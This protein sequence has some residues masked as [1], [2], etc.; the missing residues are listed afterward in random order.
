MG[1]FVTVSTDDSGVATVRLDRPKV[2]AL[3]PQ[4]W[5]E[6]AEAGR[7]CTDDDAIRSVVIWGGP[8][9]FAAGADITAMAQMDFA[10]MFG[11]G[12]RIQEAFGII[13]RIPK[14][15]I[16]AVNGYAL[17]GGCELAMTADFRY[18]GESA[19]FGQP[20]ILLGIIPGGGGTQRLPRLVGVSRAK[21]IVYTG[22]QVEAAEAERIG[23][24]DR[25]LPDDEVYDTAVET[26]RRMAEG[27]YA[28][29]MAKKA[30]DEGM[31]MD[32]DSGLRLET[33]LFTATFATEDQT[34]GM[35]SFMEQGPGKATFTGR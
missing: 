20:E 3:S 26:A 9:V 1:E 11:S 35:R 2:N 14:V 8:K 13:A 22:R 5:S 12:G 29:R 27:P 32:I 17:G 15:V 33:S 4:I 24:A 6:L 7:Q 21:E 30:I 34:I 28:L 10:E 19:V 16:A 31:D 25:V 23:L 18:A